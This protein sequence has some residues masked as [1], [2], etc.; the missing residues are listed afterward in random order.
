MV[1]W[2]WLAVTGLLLTS[3]LLFRR[4]RCLRRGWRK[5]VCVPVTITICILWFLNCVFHSPVFLLCEKGGD[6]YGGLI[7]RERVAR[8][9]G[10][11]AAETMSRWYLTDPCFLQMLCVCC[12]ARYCCPSP[13]VSYYKIQTNDGKDRLAGG[14][15]PSAQNF[16]ARRFLPAVSRWL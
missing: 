14:W 7:S 6:D 2:P 3:L 10:S 15:L 1:T 11:K 8:G 5:K 9:S 13:L 12:E 16:K 4:G